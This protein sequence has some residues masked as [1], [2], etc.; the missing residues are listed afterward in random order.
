[1]SQEGAGNGIAFAFSGA[2]KKQTRKLDLHERADDH[3]KDVLTGVGPDGGLQSA[4]PIAHVPDGPKIIPK[5]AN[6]YR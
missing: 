4:Q 3:K 5:Q 2:S 1:M 6:T